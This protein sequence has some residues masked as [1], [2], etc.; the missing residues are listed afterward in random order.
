M[1]NLLVLLK[2]SGRQ[3]KFR[4]ITTILSVILATLILTPVVYLGQG[5]L[6]R[7]EKDDFLSALLSTESKPTTEQA[8]SHGLTYISSYDTRF[9][10]LSIKEIGVRTAHQTN[11]LPVGFNKMPTDNEIWVTP[12]LKR[13]IDEHQLLKE[14][15]QGLTIKSKFPESLAPSPDSLMLLFR[16]SDAALKNPQARLGAISASDIDKIRANQKTKNNSQNQLFYTI[17]IAI[18][19]ILIT[20][21][22]VLVTEVAR[23]DTTQRERKYAT[24][25]LVGATT[26]QVG[27]IITLEALP[28]GLVGTV[29]GLLLFTQFGIPILS[30]ISLNGNAFWMS[31][32]NLPQPIYS[33]IG[34]LIVACILLSN[35]QVVRRIKLSPLIVSRSNG[36]KKHPSMLSA[37][38][39]IAGIGGLYLLSGY[40][41]S[42]YADNTATGSIVIASL[43]LLII[44]GIV[45]CGPY[46]IYLLSFAM[47]KISQ[48]ASGILA[49]YRLRLTSRNTFRSIS[50]IVIAL[51]VGSLLVTLLAI[52]QHSSEKRS[53]TV[54]IV[55]L[56]P[57]DKLQRPLQIKITESSKGID[58]ALISKLE[59]NTAL[60]DLATQTYIQ[61]YFQAKGDEEN[62]L[63]GNYYDSC[64]QLQRRTQMLCPDSFSGKPIITV[65]QITVDSSDT[66]RA[67]TRI[68]DANTVNGE[69]STS[70]YVI[71][72][73]NQAAYAQIIEL[74]ENI[75]SSYRRKT[76]AVVTV[77]YSSLDT[78]NPAAQ[79]KNLSKLIVTILAVVIATGGLSI[80]VSIVGNIYERKRTFIQLRIL[81]A[82]L[83]NLICSLAAEIAMP[84][85][86]LSVVAVSLG[87]FSCYFLLLTI[88]AFHNNQLTF[89]FPGT[90]FWV[91]LFAANLLCVSL[92]L[93][94]I[95]ILARI[96]KEGVHVE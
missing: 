42:W 96:T 5:W 19:V 18:G 93:I 52:V 22:L 26:H 87:I 49:T 59:N 15:Y 20:P 28:L 29:L 67:Q 54:P 37:I 53:E 73:K 64:Q 35:L 74:A 69:I 21:I 92:S 24:L 4:I 45:M 55:S 32:L 39:L 91:A 3:S 75:A 83:S 70:S 14:R 31:D 68:V 61:K 34:V 81:G 23:I 60:A 10:T 94:A 84:L 6:L 48:R 38:P 57:I 85:I 12:A 27:L 44:I 82:N 47:E 46:L 58:E 79:I 43:L 2:L 30:Q 88:D 17:I 62:T 33:I 71:I 51:F 63:Q 40:G 65:Q 90:H 56:L 89:T 9:R 25:S 11:K 8:K 95:P 77:G 50:G 36:V 13:L 86:M 1:N 72:A 80:F 78:M 76:G 41:K 7:Q 66:M 16:I